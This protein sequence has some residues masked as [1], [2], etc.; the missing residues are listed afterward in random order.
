MTSAPSSR[1]PWR[2]E[3]R[4]RPDL[5][6]HVT[7]LVE[8]A[9]LANAAGAPARAETLLRRALRRLDREGEV[10]DDVVVLRARVHVTHA[11]SRVQR[12]DRHGAFALLDT[13]D[14]LLVDAGP[15]HV[16]SLAVVQRAGLHGRV[17]EWE[18]T[19]ELLEGVA[20]T[21]E[22]APRTR[23]LLHLN[24]G[25]TYQ[26]LGR[27]HD[28][29]VR[30][31]RAHQD[32]VALGFPDL[33]AAA[34]HNRGR[35]QFLLGNL[36][37]ALSLTEQA[38]AMGGD[39]LPPGAVLD[40]ARVLAEAGLVDQ[41][42][43]A[44]EEGEE[45]ARAGGIAH[46]VAEADLERA[47]LAL[48]RQ[49]H[50]D[51]R[52][53]AARA[54]R[55]FS[56]GSE[57]AWAVRASLLRLQA[58]LLAGRNPG[59][60]AT[61]L[62][63]LADG[64][65]PASAVGA[66]A[67][68]LA[69]EANALVGRVDEARRNLA[70]PEVRRAASFPLRLQRT[71]ALAELH[72]AEGRPDLVRR[73]LRRGAHRL[74]VEQARHTSIDS[75]TAV[76][77]HTRRLRDAHLDLAI[78]TGSP[79]QVFDATELWRGVSQR[80][81]PMVASPDLE[82]ARLT[83]D[84]RR[85]HSEAH[86]AQDPARRSALEAA[87]RDVERAVARRDWEQAGTTGAAAEERPVTVAAL[88]PLLDRAHAGLVSLFLH[89]DL[90]WAVTVTPS[91][92][93]L[94]R[95][96]D[97]AGVVEAAARLRADLATR[98]LALGTDL[99]RVIERSMMHTA[100]ALGEALAP[101]L[102]RAHRVVVIPSSSL[103]SLPW[104]LVP[105]IRGRVVTVA[106]SATFWARRSVPA[107]SGSVA[108]TV[109]ALAGPG[110]ARATSE[111]R[112]VAR[113]WGAGASDGA[114]HDGVSTGEELRKAL[115]DS[116]IVHVAA[117]GFHQDESPLFSSVVMGD[118]PVFAHE[119]QRA[120]V[121]AEHVVLSS[122]EVGRTHVRAG[123]E[124]LGLTASLLATGVRTVVAAVGPVG[125]EDAHTVMSAYHRVLAQGLDA[126]EALEI[127]SAGVEEGRLFCAYGA[128]WAPTPIGVTSTGV[129]VRGGAVR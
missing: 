56:R 68:V 109:V 42:M 29:D 122:C 77:L 18:R 44:L 61:T 51:A 34:V 19:R 97:S 95:L 55:R 28:S 102:P 11:V 21:A 79:A 107:G 114:G 99:Q 38:R 91:G 36:P 82:L 14:G 53:Y 45:A 118:G 52:V 60:T 3:A 22:V 88:R 5:H 69:A 50:A 92:A 66:E 124:S 72:A 70:R 81:P 33:A 27:Y 127:A 8:E 1:P 86:D 90:L 26:F 39:L 64:P 30:L 89:R 54:E 106:P 115:S 10:P 121:G 25:L 13:A 80:L 113:V 65:A 119:F 74:A 120:G 16:R 126:A 78:A 87:A 31:R 103:A 98:R 83:A 7:R 67:A 62:S 4:I 46:D 23:C 123:D 85:L 73:E 9:V 108:P 125:D 129:R 71:L 94:T 111:A 117:H 100:S 2:S 15:N 112:D 59:A 41:A 43:E 93:R 76:A 104:R 49:E 101:I 128:D 20:L 84:A 6:D 35:L 63:Q 75:R 37:R 17:G 116:T 96:P 40:R 24:L 48:L 110:L 47:R 57:S 12:G 105:G 32:A 58:E